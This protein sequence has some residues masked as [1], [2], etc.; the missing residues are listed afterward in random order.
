MSR[1]SRARKSRLELEIERHRAE[2]NFNKALELVCAFKGE[3]SGLN[4]CLYNL[5]FCESRLILSEK[6]CTYAIDFKD[7]EAAVEAA[8]R[9]ADDQYRYEATILKAKI[10]FIQDQYAKV[11]EL[12][13]TGGIDL[14][15]VRIESYASRFAC[16]LSEG[17]AMLGEFDF[18]NVSCLIQTFFVFFSSNTSHGF[19]SYHVNR[20]GR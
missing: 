12:L 9:N 18:S 14:K 19:N 2:G 15:K 20:M 10:S 6:D 11:I 7:V 13:T 3:R 5:V 1:A 17:F 8:L 4:A 16:L